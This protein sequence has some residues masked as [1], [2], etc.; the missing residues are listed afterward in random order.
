MNPVFLVADD[1]ARSAARSGIQTVVRSLAGAFGG[2]GVAVRPV[3]W[4]NRLQLL[5]ALPPE[6]EIGPAAEPLRDPSRWLTAS[7]LRRQPLAWI[8][9][10]RVGGRGRFLPLHSHP[11]HRRAPPGSWVLLPE[12]MYDGKAAQLADYVHRRGWRLAAIFYDTIPVDR[13]DLVPL[14]LPAKH[15]RYMRDLTGADL[16]LPISETSAEGWRDFVAREKLPGPPVR[17]CTLACDLV[18]TPRVRTVAPA[19]QPG[20]PVRIL[21]VSTLE[22][23]KN[24]GALLDAYARALAALPGVGLELHLVGAPYVGSRNL[25]DQ[26]CAAMNRFPGLHWHE[27]VEYT[28]LLALYEQCDFTVYPSVLEGFGLPVIESLWL[29]RPCVCAD[30]GVMAENAAGGGCLPVDVRDPTAL[31][32]AVLTLVDTPELCRRLAQEAV[33]RPLKTWDEYAD[34]VLGCLGEVPPPKRLRS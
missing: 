11:L 23:R 2:R 3:I 32:D 12:L 16:I 30:F 9:W 28:Q 31:A 17:T 26:V 4:N 34:E 33:S 20:E 19:R 8:P 24:H 21:C 22:P 18:G 25:V 10:L 29:G 5:R 27:Q 13:P 6:L 7:L 1:T 15:A 14:E